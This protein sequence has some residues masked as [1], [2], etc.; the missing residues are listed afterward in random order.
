MRISFL[1]SMNKVVQGLQS[2]ELQRNSQR[3]KQEIWVLMDNGV[4]QVEG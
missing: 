3:R 2:S 4:N 1:F